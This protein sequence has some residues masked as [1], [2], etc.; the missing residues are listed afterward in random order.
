[1]ISLQNPTFSS[2]QPA[3]GDELHLSLGP[4]LGQEQVD[5][6]GFAKA[7]YSYVEAV[8][9]V[10]TN[11]LRFRPETSV[12]S[13]L[14]WAVENPRWFGLHGRYFALLLAPQDSTAIN[15]LQP[16]SRSFLEPSDG[17]R[18]QQV[19]LEWG[20]PLGRLN[21]GESLTWSFEV[22]SGPK[23]TTALQAG[24]H[25]YDHILLPGLWA[26]LRW[27]SLALMTLLTAIHALV[28][29]WGLAVL[30]LALVV[31]L[32]MYPVANNAMQQQLKFVEI[33]KRIAPE[34]ARIKLELRGEEQSEKILR[35]YE[36]HGTSPLA[37]L[38]P[39][40]IVLLQ[41]PVLIA[42]FHGLGG[43]Y[44]LRDASFLWMDSLAEPDHLFAFGFSV[45]VLG[46]YFNLLPVLM[47]ATTLATINLSPAPASNEK[48]NK[49]QS[50]FLIL[51]ALIFF[52]LFY[53]FPSGMVLYWTAA[54]ALHVGQ[55]C[56]VKILR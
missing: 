11:V 55:Q 14:S 6:S 46:E 3:P 16:V 38:K 31:R 5:R 22:Y 50:W 41:L 23:S 33:Q 53:S 2:Y 39:L 8:A 13:E 48:E 40:F 9:L 56:L 10:D 27:L 32:L 12:A 52:L 44:E 26:W 29:S 49:Q 7:L 51:M 35:L 28:P 54:N 4:G 34:L 19:V 21:P 18:V 36:Q 45:P 37:G 1:M 25:G 24:T 17:N 20:L 43:V 42:L 30:V 47:A 15:A